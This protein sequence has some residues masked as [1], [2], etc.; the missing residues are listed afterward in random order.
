M[1]DPSS[2]ARVSGPLSP[3]AAGFR[4]ALLERGYRPGTVANQLQLMA[5]L[6][7]WLVAH[8]LEP[9]AL[10]SARIERFVQERQASL[11]Q[12]VSV[13][14]RE[15][16]GR[17][18]PSAPRATPPTGQRRAHADTRATPRSAPRRRWALTPRPT[19]RRVARSFGV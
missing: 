6:S 7:R 12:F 9:A 11:S 8:D 13:R 14:G 2:R 4:E 19:S 10:G 18:P 16:A 15:Q 17:R 5:H 1:S 3:F